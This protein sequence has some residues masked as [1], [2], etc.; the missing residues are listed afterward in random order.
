MRSPYVF[1]DTEANYRTR[2]QTISTVAD[3]VRSLQR[4]GLRRLSTRQWITYP[5][6][7]QRLT[8][9]LFGIV[10]GAACVYDRSSRPTLVAS[11]VYSH[12]RTQGSVHAASTTAAAVDPSATHGRPGSLKSQPRRLAPRER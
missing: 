9:L 7:P 6:Y 10:G 12:C 2:A 3:L 8:W 4:R 11:P 5:Q 1:A